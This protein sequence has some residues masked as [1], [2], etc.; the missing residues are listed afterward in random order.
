MR[1]LF[2][3]FSLVLSSFFLMGPQ[4][5]KAQEAVAPP[6]IDSRI[7]EI[8][9]AAS[10]A[11]VEADIRTLAGFGTR[12]TFSDTISDT[13]GIGAARRWIKAEFD[14]ISAECGGCLEVSYQTIMVPAS[15]RVPQE[16]A[17]VS[18]VAIQRGTLYP[19][20][21]VIMAG[22][23]DSRASSGN[24]GE[25]D[26]PGANDNATGM[27]GAIEAARLLT[28]HSFPTSIAYAGLSA[29]EQ[30]L[31]GGQKMAA[32]ALEE[33]WEIAAGSTSF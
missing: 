32:V 26:A 10:P 16:T 1:R 20:R 17:V 2:F 4:L 9:S 3:I 29:E 13:R 24:D 30:G 11:R 18:V 23:I 15:R 5:L 25:T 12:N 6:Q 7:Y 31:Y 22:D 14:Q 33:G 21:Y 19:N 28:K 27:A 8:I